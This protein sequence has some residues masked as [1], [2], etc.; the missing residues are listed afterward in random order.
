MAIY[1]TQYQISP[2]IN[3]KRKSRAHGRNREDGKEKRE[4]KTVTE[5]K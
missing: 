2:R 3:R 1:C 4:I 5:G